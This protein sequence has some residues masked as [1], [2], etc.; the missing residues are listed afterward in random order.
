MGNGWLSNIT[1]RCSAVAMGV[2]TDVGTTV[3]ASSTATY[4][5]VAHMIMRFRAHPAV[6]L[7]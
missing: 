1:E 7:T 5:N 2:P 6:E 4:A 3:T